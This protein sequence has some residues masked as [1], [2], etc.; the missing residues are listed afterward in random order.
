MR[1]RVQPVKK[2]YYSLRSVTGACL[3]LIL[4]SDPVPWLVR[5]PSI[6]VDNGVHHPSP[7]LKTMPSR[8][9]KRPSQVRRP[10]GCQEL[11]TYIVL[12]YLPGL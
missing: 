2:G 5:P 7:R 11:G 6:S 9:A 12:S 8:E 10:V 3:A 1:F 4:R